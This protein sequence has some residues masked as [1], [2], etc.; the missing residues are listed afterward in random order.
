MLSAKLEPS[1]PERPAHTRAP[2]RCARADL[3]LVKKC[4]KH[5]KDLL[6]MG[7]INIVEAS[8]CATWATA[9]VWAAELTSWPPITDA[10]MVRHPS[11]MDAAWEVP[12]PLHVPSSPPRLHNLHNR[13]VCCRCVHRTRALAPSAQQSARSTSG[14]TAQASP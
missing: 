14:P 8:P 7:K 9:G 10:N 3:K 5:Y 12:P 13:Q 4:T 2:L 6:S 1:Y 11:E